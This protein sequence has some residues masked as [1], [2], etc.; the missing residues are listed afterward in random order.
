MTNIND[1]Q[2][3]E[4]MCKQKFDANF[5]FENNIEFSEQFI[6]VNRAIQIIIKYG[7]GFDK[8]MSLLLKKYGVFNDIYMYVDEPRLPS[9]IKYKLI[10]K[11]ND[12]NSCLSFSDR[13]I[14]EDEVIEIGLVS[15]GIKSI[16]N[17]NI[18]LDS[19]LEYV[20]EK[21][22]SSGV[23]KGELLCGLEHGKGK[24]Y[25]NNGNY[26]E[27]E[28]EQGKYIKGKYFYKDIGYYEGEF[29]N[30]KKEGKG[31]FVTLDGTVYVGCYRNDFFDGK[32]VVTTSNNEYY[33]CDYVE[34]NEIKR[35]KIVHKRK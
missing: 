13:L 27:G 21:K 24:F 25:F 35:E 11:A 34:G 1:E 18:V 8:T 19:D 20:G 15:V 2:M 26:I 23:Y 33:I 10:A 3:F 30:G 16:E 12:I 28:W 6:S 9:N 29:I 32:V 22:Y 7:L 31:K 5:C 14:S 4:K 17:K